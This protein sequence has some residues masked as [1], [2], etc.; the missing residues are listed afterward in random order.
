MSEYKVRDISYANIEVNYIDHMG[1]DARVRNVAWTSFDRWG[2]E[3]AELLP[4]EKGLLSYLATGLPASERDDWEN[5][6]KAHTHWTTFAHCQLSIRC[7]APIFLSRQ[8]AKS[9]I[10]LVWNEESRRYISSDV[11]L[12][13]PSIIHGAPENAKQGATKEPHV[14]YV[15]HEFGE[16]NPQ[17]QYGVDTPAIDVIK[18]ASERSVETYYELIH[19]KVAPE[20]AR[21]VLPQNAMTNWIWTGSMLAFNRVYQLRKDSHAQNAAQEFAHGLGEILYEHFPE[22][23]KALNM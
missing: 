18:W 1:S 17:P 15:W 13:V 11:E 23:M 3:E 16:G 21:M 10:G 9:Q 5:R 2:D 22:S 12:Y 6:A 14:G 7:K 19:A 4:K 20:E 8:L